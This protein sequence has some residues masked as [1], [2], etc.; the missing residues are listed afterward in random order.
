MTMASNSDGKSRDSQTRIR[1]SIFR[2][3]ACLGDLRLSTSSCWRRTRISASREA[4][5]ASNE[6]SA[7]KILVNNA[8]IAR[9]SITLAEVRHA[10]EVLTRHTDLNEELREKITLKDGDRTKK[11]SKQRAIVKTLVNKTLKG[12]AR[13][14]NTLISLVCR[15]S[16]LGASEIIDTEPLM[17]DE[18]EILAELENE[19]VRKRS[20]NT[21]PEE[22]QT[23]GTNS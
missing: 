16:D 19:V 5:T 15:T 23:G 6:R 20:P 21:V 7:S 2:S 13:A 14:A 8:S 10:A 9:C 3:R 11:I 12:D 4:G 18:L 1:R 22:D 17:N